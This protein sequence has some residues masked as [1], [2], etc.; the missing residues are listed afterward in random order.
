MDRY[1]VYLIN[2]PHLPI[3]YTHY[4]FM[5]KFKNGFRQHG[6]EVFEINTVSQLFNII[7]SPK[8]IFLYSNHYN[9]NKVE[10]IINKIAITFI[11]T[12]HLGWYFH[13][14]VL[15]KN[16]PLQKV[17]LTGQYS[18]EKRETHLEN[19]IVHIQKKIY[20]IPLFGGSEINPKNL[21]IIDKTNA[22]YNCCFV[23][24]PYKKGWTN[25]LK[26]CYYY[27]CVKNK[28]FL[29]GDEKIN[30]YN[31]SLIMLGFHSD[32]NQ[33]LNVISDRIYEGL[34]SCCV[35][36]T[37]SKKAAEITNEIAVY[38]ANQSELEEKVN[39]YLKNKNAR[40]EKIKQG[41][42][43]LKNEGTF[44]HCAKLFLD[45]IEKIF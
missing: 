34:R 8:N 28:K 43:Y 20:Y 16:I 6:C 17:I 19:S 41:I 14:L 33:K 11:E 32:N 44:Y 26:K 3:T 30:I 38:V 12:I 45:H 1:K 42:E 35:V 5:T 29:L 24:T 36:L 9:Q 13:D 37:D 23:G 2:T 22:K 7:D 40:D 39:F 25:N 15:S 4:V 10:K 31:S 27:D 21:K 18:F